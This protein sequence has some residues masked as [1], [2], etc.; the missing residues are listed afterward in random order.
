[1]KKRGQGLST[2]SIILLILGIVVLVMLIAGFTMGWGKIAPWISKNNVD[3]IVKSCASSCSTN[4]AYDYC[5]MERELKDEKANKVIAS[6]YALSLSHSDYKIGKCENLCDTLKNCNSGKDNLRGTLR[7]LAD[8]GCDFK[9]EK[10]V[11]SLET[12]GLNVCCVS[13][14]E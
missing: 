11:A 4:S 1:M 6:C 10:E 14:N 9:I 3:T 5:V 8:G 2:N 13:L 7:K 12:S